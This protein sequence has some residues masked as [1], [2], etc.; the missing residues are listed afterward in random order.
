MS[1][2]QIIQNFVNARDK[3]P[4]PGGKLYKVGVVQV[5]T[6]VESAWFRCLK[7]KYDL[8]SVAFN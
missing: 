1:L 8:S 7:L 3:I 6:R 4:M 2:Q 5:Q